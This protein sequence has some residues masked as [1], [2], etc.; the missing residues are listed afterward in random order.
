MLI[1]E[2]DQITKRIAYLKERGVRITPQRV[3]ILKTI[4]SLLTNYEIRI[5]QFEMYGVCTACQDLQ[6]R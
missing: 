3:L 6:Q 4:I 5:H 2:E 1:V